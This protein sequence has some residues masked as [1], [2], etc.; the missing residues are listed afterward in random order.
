MSVIRRLN[1]N[2]ISQTAPKREAVRDFL[3]NKSY[4]PGTYIVEFNPRSSKVMSTNVLREVALRIPGGGSADSLRSL[5][6]FQISPEAASSL[7]DQSV[8]QFIVKQEDETAPNLGTSMQN[9]RVYRADNGVTM[10]E[11]TADAPNVVS[12]LTVTVKESSGEEASY[13]YLPKAFLQR[14]NT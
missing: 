13:P 11:P 8:V 3:Q 4:Q 10:L 14:R 1:K 6:R 5:A 7:P 12:P 2:E 9:Y